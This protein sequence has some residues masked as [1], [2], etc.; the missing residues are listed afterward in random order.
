M[1]TTEKTSVI[2]AEFAFFGP[3]GF[4]IGAYLANLLLS[5]FSQDGH[6]KQA[7]D[8]KKRPEYK[9]WLL[10]QVQYFWRQLIYCLLMV[11]VDSADVEP[12]YS[13]VHQA[14]EQRVFRRSFF[15][16]SK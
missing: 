11:C 2:D 5:F 10:Q 9:Q 15:I 14:L 7:A 8:D 6:A 16:P 3:M 12:L 4:D 1:V 13:K